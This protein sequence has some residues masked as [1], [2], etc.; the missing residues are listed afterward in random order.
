[1]ITLEA[2]LKN[3]DQA[4]PDLRRS[5]VFRPTQVKVTTSWEREATAGTTRGRMQLPTGSSPFC[6]GQW[7]LKQGRSSSSGST[8]SFHGSDRA[9][10]CL[11]GEGNQK[12]GRERREEWRMSLK[13]KMMVTVPITQE[14]EGARKT[15]EGEGM[16]HAGRK[17]IMLLLDPFLFSNSNKSK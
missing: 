2:N 10:A 7:R 5:C 14:R 4:W 11:I 13:P 12:R 9:M 6:Y 1:M 15:G 16:V 8:P 3:D 17:Q